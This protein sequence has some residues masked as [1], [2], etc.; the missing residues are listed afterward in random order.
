VNPHL[1]LGFATL[2]VALS[3]TFIAV[4]TTGLVIPFLLA[5][6]ALAGV[7]RLCHTR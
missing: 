2:I 4:A 5:L 6:A 7:M 1:R 3:G